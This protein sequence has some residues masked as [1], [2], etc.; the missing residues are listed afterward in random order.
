MPQ[1]DGTALPTDWNTTPMPEGF[2]VLPFDKPLSDAE[3]SRAARGLI[4]QQ[5]EDK[6]FIYLHPETG[7]LHFHRSWTGICVY[8]VRVE[9]D[10]RGYRCTEAHANRYPEEYRRTND[11]YDARLIH[12]LI[13][14]LLLGY[15]VPFPLEDERTPEQAVL[16]QFHSIGYGRAN[17]KE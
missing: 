7:W 17:A 13:D 6:W 12:F 9:R 15:A 2:V 11:A 4:P 1:E 16:S 3:F 14:A 10:G 8:R 5:M